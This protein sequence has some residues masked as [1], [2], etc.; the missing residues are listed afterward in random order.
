MRVL[1]ISVTRNRK[2]LPV[3]A[4]R[5]VEGEMIR[6]GRG[7]QCEIHLPDP[8]VA[9]FHAAIYRQGDSIFIHAPE[10]E[11]AVD[12]GA[13]R[14]ARLTP[15]VHVALG[16][17]EMT[18]EPPPSGC[19]LSLAI[20]LVRPLPDDLAEI[21]AKSRT[22]LEETVLSKRGPAWILA[23]VL[24]IVFLVAPTLNAVLPLLRQQ[25]AKLP[26]T[27]DQAW[28]PGT[29]SAGHQA[30]GREC[31][32]CHETPFVHVRDHV[33]IECHVKTPGHLQTVA[34]QT[35][36][37][38]GTRCA[39]CHADHKGPDALVRHD[40]DLCVTCHGDLK[41]FKADTTL[42]NTTDFAANHPPFKLSL[43]QGPG[44]TDVVRVSQTDKTRLVER[45]NLKFPHDLHLTTS[46]RGPKGRK[47]LECRSCHVPDVSG[48]G[49]EPIAMNTACIECHT[50]EFEPAV[51]TRQVPHGSVDDVMLTMQEFY[52]NIALNNI[53]VDV[54]DIGEIQR[55]LPRLG[56]GVITEEQRRRALAWAKY[57]AQQVSADL[58]EARVCIV[59]HEVTKAVIQG[60][61]GR[62]IA[63]GVAPVRLAS[64]W[65]PKAHFD[66]LKHR[67]NKCA[68]CHDVAKSHS[69]SDIAIPTIAK[70]RDCH[71]GNKPAADKVV[72][73]CVACHDFHLAGHPPFG[74]RAD[75]ALPRQVQ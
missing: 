9:L 6:L 59:C 20:E 7:T 71:A 54:V 8:R 55:G 72:S 73:T 23:I 52:A 1:V 19:D 26:I 29:L 28:N 51:T 68:D 2:G 38:G 13:E 43:L 46:V 27:P 57:K 75:L 67:T 24:G 37:F 63:W 14:E 66:H 22:S 47:T 60:E 62:E 53:P 5:I 49:F 30:F 56:S 45:S 3:R 33:C 64:T 44:R 58:F 16:P 70:C 4:E 61:S 74:A 41:Y 21:R 40:P 69:S 39:N 10:A 12:G 32:T 17:Y 15:R 18:V 48:K 50:L 65:M 42:G 25:S 11:L 35:K 34:L 36:L 31:G